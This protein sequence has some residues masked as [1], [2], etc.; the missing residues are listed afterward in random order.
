MIFMKSNFEE[1]PMRKPF[2]PIRFGVLREPKSEELLKFN[3]EGAGAAT[4]AR[5]KDAGVQ[6]INTDDSGEK[7]PT[8][9]AGW[10]VKASDEICPSLLSDK[11]LFERC[12]H[13]GLNARLWTRKFAG[14]LPE[15]AKRGLHRRKGFISIHEFAAKV[16]GMSEYAVDKILNL[17]KKLEDKP[18]LR[19]LFESGA[20]GWSKIS[21]VAYVASKDTDEAWA[22]KV[23]ALSQKA[24][25]VYVQA[26]R[27]EI[28]RAGEGKNK[29]LISQIGDGKEPAN[30][31]IQAG[32]SGTI[33]ES[34]NGNAIGQVEAGQNL[35]NLQWEE[36]VRF[37]FPV[38]R[39]VEFD[40]RLIKQKLEKDTKQTL[41]WNET[42]GILVNKNK[43]F[44]NKKSVKS[45]PVICKKCSKKAATVVACDECMKL[46]NEKK[47]SKKNQK[48]N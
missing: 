8:N 28:T 2:L 30:K 16:G 6:K 33:S 37:S 18:A 24:L 32:A 42:F 34:L 10:I 43:E 5:S 47:Y 1:K 21:T 9:G 45:A 36:P 35:A 15:V 25:E 4:G 26:Y 12:Q 14:L 48:G 39:N 7:A 13:C 27:L 44:V 29:N 31:F 17:A 38:S 19:K 40:L 11:E 46:T 41:S 3:M 23:Q 22:E 20:E